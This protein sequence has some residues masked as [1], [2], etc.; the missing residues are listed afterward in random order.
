[1][2]SYQIHLIRHGVT[3]ANLDGQYIGR[4]DVPLAPEGIAELKKL[5]ATGA[6]PKA[7]VY[8]TSPRLRCIQSMNILYPGEDCYEV[9][10][11]DEIDF[12]DWEGKTAEELKGDALFEKWLDH[13]ADVTPPNG[14]SAEAMLTR[15]R[16]TF[17][18]IVDGMIRSQVTSAVIMTHGGVIMNLLAAYGLPEASFYDWITPPGQ[19]YSVRIMPSI[20]MNGNKVEV[21]DTIPGSE[22]FDPNDE[23]RLAASLGREAA[24]RSFGPTRP[25]EEP[26]RDNWEPYK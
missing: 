9:P 10:G 8:Y 16:S 11:F 7:E 20:W 4:T 6:Y 3:T 12:G 13:S 1:M 25:D 2:Q 5:A 23:S 17:E 15:V 22:Y 26:D 24:E 21:F 19:G 18:A 14:E